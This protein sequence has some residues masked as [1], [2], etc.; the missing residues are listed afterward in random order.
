M[1]L[2]MMPLRGE[3]NAPQKGIAQMLGAGRE[4]G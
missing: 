2:A 1:P 4:G 3:V